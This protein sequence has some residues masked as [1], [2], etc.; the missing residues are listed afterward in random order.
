MAKQKGPTTNATQ[1][2]PTTNGHTK[3]TDNEWPHI[4]D[5]QRMATKRTDNDFQSTTQ[6]TK[7]R[8]TRTLL[9]TGNE[10]VCFGRVGSSCSTSATRFHQ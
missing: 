1:K 5:Q 6:K 9:N 8:A 7:D 10:L 2:E 4:K 3:R